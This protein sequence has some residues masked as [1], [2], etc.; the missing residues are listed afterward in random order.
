MM[1]F[2]SYLNKDKTKPKFF[3]LL[4]IFDE[5]IEDLIDVELDRG[6]D[7]DDDSGDDVG[8]LERV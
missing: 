8:L 5:S 6:V 7:D 4:V 1:S 2:P 3:D